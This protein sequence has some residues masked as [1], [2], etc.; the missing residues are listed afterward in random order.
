MVLQALGLEPIIYGNL[1]LGEGTGAVAVFPL[2][3]MAAAVYGQM[4]TFSQIKI[5][6]YEHLS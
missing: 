3:D 6:E 5:K 1:C 4:S 2:L